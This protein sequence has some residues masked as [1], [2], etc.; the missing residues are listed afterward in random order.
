M[1]QNRY[2]NIYLAVLLFF[3]VCYR[4][5]NQY[6]HIDGDG[7]IVT[8]TAVLSLVYLGLYK[9]YIKETLLSFPVLIW[10]FLMT[11]QIVHAIIVNTY[12][13]KYNQI[14]VTLQELGIMVITAHLFWFD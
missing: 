8:S 3:L 14:I 6:T 11:Y 9:K 5:L 2:L 13:P 4:A 10:A 12:D 7:R 1:A